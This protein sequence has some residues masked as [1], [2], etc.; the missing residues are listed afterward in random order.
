MY[1]CCAH[2]SRGGKKKND[3]DNKKLNQNLEGI[4]DTIPKITEVMEF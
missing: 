1:Q 3:T 4:N 2:T